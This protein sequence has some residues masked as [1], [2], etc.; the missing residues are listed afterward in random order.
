MGVG[1]VA[2]ALL[3]WAAWRVA[4]PAERLLSGGGSGSSGS[5]GSDGSPPASS[6]LKVPFSG[7]FMS[8]RAIAGNGAGVSTAAAGMSAALLQLAPTPDGFR[9]ACGEAW[10]YSGTWTAAEQQARAAAMSFAW[11][12]SSASRRAEV[13]AG[14]GF[15][16]GARPLTTRP[17]WQL[18]EKSLG[19]KLHPSVR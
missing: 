12:G 9:A 1:A 18:P 19:G 4:Q 14:S 16:G 7:L 15:G 6:R 17:V 11:P 5:S 2:L 8:G 13:P 10:Q 3:L